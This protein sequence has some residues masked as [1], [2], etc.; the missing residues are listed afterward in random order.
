MRQTAQLTEADEDPIQQC[1]NYRPKPNRQQGFKIKGRLS[2]YKE[3]SDGEV[4]KKHSR[5][6]IATVLGGKSKYLK[7][8][9]SVSKIPFPLDH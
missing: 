4:E 5:T 3:I 1:N 6:Y 8:Q 9:C 7:S 2:Q